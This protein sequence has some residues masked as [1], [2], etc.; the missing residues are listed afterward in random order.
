MNAAIQE[1]GFDL[2]TADGPILFVADA[3]NKLERNLLEHWIQM[4]PGDSVGAPNWVVLTITREISASA[5]LEMAEKLRFDAASH[6]RDIEEVKRSFPE[7]PKPLGMDGGEGARLPVFVL[8]MSRSGKTLVESVL[9]QH[10]D[11]YSAGEKHEWINAV[12]TVLKR[13][14]ISEPFPRCMAVLTGAQIREMG[15]L[16]MEGMSRYAPKLRVLVNTLPGNYRYIPLIFQALPSA[17]VVFCRRDPLDHCLFVYIKRYA[18]GN[19][20]S[21]DL[22]NVAA[23]YTDYYGLLAHWQ[24]LYGKHILEVRYEDLVRAPAET[25]ARLFAYCGLDFDPA[26]TPDRFGTD[27]IGRSQHYEPYLGPLRQALGELAR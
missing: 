7:A 2:S 27:E 25:G 10:R 14:E 8:G 5:L 13:H 24:E 26:L 16:Y 19:R 9:A 11:V 1:I 23:Y 3:R 6:R 17:K 22:K 4:L 18:D 20:H 12:E 15:D 21:Y